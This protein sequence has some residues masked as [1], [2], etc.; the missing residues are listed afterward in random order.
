MRPCLDIPA[1]LDTPVSAYLKLAP[2][3]ARF[4]LE[5]VEYGNQSGRYSIIGFGDGEE[6]KFPA[7][8]LADGLSASAVLQE[9]RKA[10][11]RAPI[12]GDDEAPLAGGLVGLGSYEL[13]RLLMGID[14]RA[15]KLHDAPLAHYFAPRMTL[16]FDHRAR[17][18]RLFHD[19]SDAE[20]AALAREVSV[21]LAG[22][23]ESRARRSRSSEIQANQSAAEFLSRV[24]RGKE[25]IRAGDAYQLVLSVRF[26]AETDIDPFTAYRAL[27]LLNPSPYM[28]YLDFGGFRVA[29]SSPEALV[30]LTG[31]RAYVRPIAGTR[32][33]GT[34]ADEDAAAEAALLAD[35]K[36]IAEHMMLVDLARNDIGRVART[37]SV[38]VNPLKAIERY[39]H[40]MHIVSG[41]EGELAPD[42]DAFDL[43]QSAFP[44]GTLSGAPKRRAM[45]IIDE[46]EPEGRG[47]YGGAVGYFGANGDMDHAIAIRSMTFSKGRCSFQAG[48]GI[49]IDSSPER[50][51]EEILAKSAIM[52]RALSIAETGL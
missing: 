10:V 26:S 41:V 16:V 21:L 40:V 33:R 13:A 1:D 39:S 12:F 43:F 23:I 49:V 52:R 5:S 35:P 48:A 28:F 29:G 4:L 51:H 25:L 15:E 6:L 7:S 37:G 9:L 3:R 30:R 50:E 31:G 14:A 38:R 2:L 36:E 24:E 19:G 44:A 8:A 46:L 42:R 11:A 20:R 18:I 34:T 32:P 27:R 47:L 45:E 22:A 17:R